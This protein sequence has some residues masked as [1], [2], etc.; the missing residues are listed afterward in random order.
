MASLCT[1]P[2]ITIPNPASVLAAIIAL[3]EGLGVQIP[4]IPT[5]PLPAPFCPLDAPPGL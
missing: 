2:S 5:I 3:L 1:P 4:P